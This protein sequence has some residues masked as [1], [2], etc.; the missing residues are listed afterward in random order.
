MIT[1]SAW[2]HQT[3]DCSSAWNP[4]RQKS[5]QYAYRIQTS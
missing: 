2:G 4:G 5:L 1:K 3:A